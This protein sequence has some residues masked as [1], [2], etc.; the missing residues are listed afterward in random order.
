MIL[1]EMIERFQ[2][3]LDDN[4]YWNDTRAIA[5][6]N[7][8][9][10]KLAQELRVL[11]PSYYTFDSVQGQQSYEVPSKLIANQL[12]YY[13]SSYNQIIRIVK[14]PQSIYGPYS[15]VD[16]QGFPTI[17]YIWGVSGR[18]QLTVF[19]TFNV[20]D[21]TIQWWFWGWPEDLANYN[22]EPQMPT[23]WHSSLVEGT[24]DLVTRGGRYGTFDN[25]FPK[26]QSNEDK[27]DLSFTVTGAAGSGVIW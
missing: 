4:V 27:E 17:G 15:E 21:I 8:M 13:N 25:V 6:V 7:T 23:P 5:L 26:I 24:V 2:A 14:G 18:R 3:R 11:A 1:R 10:D 12:L 19:P 9:K 20:D 22:D 16:Q